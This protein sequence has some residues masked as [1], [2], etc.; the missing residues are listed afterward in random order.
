MDLREIG[1][2]GVDWI[3]VTPATYKWRTV[4]TTAKKFRVPWKA[5]FFLEQLRTKYIS[6]RNLSLVSERV[7]CGSR[8]S[9]ANVSDENWRKKKLS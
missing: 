7:L 8:T 9:I 3:N 5:F 1:L 4:A 2:D 6:R